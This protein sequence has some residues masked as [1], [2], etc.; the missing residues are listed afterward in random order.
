MADAAITIRSFRVCFDLERRIHRI[1]RWRLPVPYGLPVRSIGYWAAALATL[2]VL[3]RLPV[4]GAVIAALPVPLR[5]VVLP[6][7]AAYL[8]TQLRVDGRAA[9]RAGA[10]LVR[11]R[12]A[13][14][15]LV[16]F[17]PRASRRAERL[18]DMPLARDEASARYRRG[19]VEG[20]AVV[21]LRYPASAR[22]R[23]RALRVTQR[24]RRPMWRG[25]RIALRAG[26][27]LELR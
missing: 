23:G 22:R 27:R 10:A 6:S 17:R 8:L 1:D 5:L 7:V 26:Q 16:A 4:T 12:V 11:H 2:L 15:E 19:V 3:G 18:A 25:K 9:H 21:T 14:R 20:P 13:P 24:D